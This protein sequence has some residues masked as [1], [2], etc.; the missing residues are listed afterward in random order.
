MRSEDMLEPRGAAHGSADAAR[1]RLEAL[2]YRQELHRAMSL[3]D[4]VVY[5]LI[6]MVPLAPLAV[7]GF[8]YNL[9]GGRVAAVYIVAAIAMYFSAVSYSVMALEFPVAGSVYSY[10]RF[11]AG[12]FLGFLSGW[13]I[14]LDYLLLPGL[15]CIFAAAAMHAQVPAI[16]EWIWVPVFVV[17]STAINLRGITFTAG[18]NLAC[19]YLQLA[20]LAGFVAYVV[21]ALVAGR[22]H[23]SFAPILGNGAFSAPLVFAAVP[24]AALSYI[25]FDAI[26]TLNEEA[27]GGGEAVARAT[28][29]V[30]FAVAV[31]F[32]LQVY[33]AALFVPPGTTFEGGAAA[34][35]FYDIA[36]VAAGAVFKTIITL[37]SALIAILAN[38]IVSQ[39]TTSRLIFSMARDRQIP[40]FL[41]AVH[42]RRKVPVRAILTVALFSMGIGLLAVNVPDFITSVVTFGCLTAYCLLHVAVLRHFRSPGMRSR[43]FAHV[44]SPLV[45]LAILVYALWRSALPAKEVGVAWIVTGVVVYLVRRRTLSGR[46]RLA[47]RGSSSGE[48]A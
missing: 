3:L 45:G 18:V 13:S 44:I 27:K 47:Q 11:G 26:S 31:M 39:A 7:F 43:L 20:V 35:A 25:G 48:R 16:P 5:G 21:I 1:A 19:L 28:M 10:V 42:E 17:I 33:L 40:R 37:T 30:L 24:I 41:A 29:I 38:A 46:D 9:S 34:T 2:G 8:T 12:E 14:L 32:V 4:V 23:L 36:Q 22:T 6:Y 15:L